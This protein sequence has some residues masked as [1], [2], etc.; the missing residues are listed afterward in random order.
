MI[1][2]PPQIFIIFLS[3]MH[4]TFI[5]FV[6]LCTLTIEVTRVQS[7]DLRFS[8]VP[9]VIWPFSVQ[10]KVDVLGPFFSM[11]ARDHPHWCYHIF[12]QKS[13]TLHPVPNNLKR[14]LMPIS[15]TRFGVPTHIYSLVHSFSWVLKINSWDSKTHCFGYNA[16]LLGQKD[17]IPLY[18]EITK[19]EPIVAGAS[20]QNSVCLLPHWLYRMLFGWKEPRMLPPICVNKRW[21]DDSKVPKT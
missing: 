11:T 21:H 4:P 15:G 20:K 10:E 14:R 16:C 9:F 12:M 3:L 8:I 18:R 17:P 5:G 2:L 19:R 1:V 6:W 13:F 7:S